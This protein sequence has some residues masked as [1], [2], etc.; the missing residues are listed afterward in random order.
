MMMWPLLPTAK[1][2]SGSTLFDVPSPDYAY[3]GAVVDATTIGA[4]CGLLSNLSVAT[5]DPTYGLYS[6]DVD[7]LGQVHFPAQGVYVSISLVLS[8]H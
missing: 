2:L 6:V 7:G 4:E 8:L 5:W 1:G 3:T